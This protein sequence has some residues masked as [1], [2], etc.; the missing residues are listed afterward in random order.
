MFKFFEKYKRLWTGGV[1]RSTPIYTVWKKKH[2]HGLI[3][4]HRAYEVK[5]IS[6]KVIILLH[7]DI[8]LSEEYILENQL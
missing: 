5:H 8:S 3:Y 6:L 2:V 1:V 4:V 7:K